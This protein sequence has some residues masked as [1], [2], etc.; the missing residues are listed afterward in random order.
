MAC[1]TVFSMQCSVNGRETARDRS[2]TPVP[3]SSNSHTLDNSLKHRMRSTDSAVSALV[4]LFRARTYERSLFMLKNADDCSAR[5]SSHLRHFVNC[6]RLLN[7]LHIVSLRGRLCQGYGLG[8]HPLPTHRAPC[9]RVRHNIGHVANFT[10]S[11]VLSL[12]AHGA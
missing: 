9:P 6:V 4:H 7:L 2:G 12:F 11:P 5:E 10:I 1:N 8:I 3:R